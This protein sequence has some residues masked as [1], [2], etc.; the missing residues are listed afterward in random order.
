MIAAN[1]LFRIRCTFVSLLLG[2]IL[3]S[4]N[5]AFADE[6]ITTVHFGD[7]DISDI[8]SVFV[9]GDG[10][11]IIYSGSAPTVA[12]P[13]QLPR[14]FLESWGITSSTVQDTVEGAREKAQEAK[15]KSFERALA[16]GQFRVVNGVVYDL[17]RAQPG[18]ASCRNVR[19]VLKISD[20]EAVL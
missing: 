15:Q 16:T 14:S 3:L 6:K 17:R 11:I 12:D 5:S 18:W 20:D 13:A 2:L 7:Q 9:R 4:F 10:K 19:M 8:T 1:H